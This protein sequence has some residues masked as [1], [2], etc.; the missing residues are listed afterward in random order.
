MHKCGTLCH[1]GSCPPCT[2]SSYEPLYCRCRRTYIAPPVPCGTSIPT[3]PYLCIVPRPC[4]HPS[5][6]NCHSER[7]LC[8]VCTVPVQKYCASHQQPT[9]YH[10]PCHLTDVSCGRKCH[11]LLTCCGRLC[12]LSCHGGPCKHECSRTFPSF[13]DIAKRY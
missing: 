13:A 7:E 8:P 3:C 5:M 9:P 11:K 4:G 2:H 1:S 10:M 6:H 12:E